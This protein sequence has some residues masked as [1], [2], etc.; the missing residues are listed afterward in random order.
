M[1]RLLI[2]ICSTNLAASKDFYARLFDFNVDFDSDWFVHLVSQNKN[3]ELGII[4]AKSDV[5][6]PG[7]NSAAE[8][9]YL[10]MVIDNVDD[11][12]ERN[13]DELDVIEPPSD[14]FYGQRR[15]LIKDP[16]G[17]VIDV[18]SLIPS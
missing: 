16:N 1:D 5:V 9:F 15:L 8:G 2:N 10:T 3:L 14:T 17:V 12:F 6:P 11:F 4:D 13:Q 18:S 7:L